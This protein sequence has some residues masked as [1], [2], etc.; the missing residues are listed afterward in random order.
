MSG[1]WNWLDDRTGVRRLIHEALY[2]RI[3][4]GARWRYVWGSTLVF[5][6][7]TQAVTGFLLWMAY[8]PGGQSAWESVYYIQHEMQYGWLLRGVH[9]FM[10]QA[11]VV[12]LVLH[13]MQVIID[14]AYRAPREINFWLGL[15]LMQLVLGL[16]LTGY[17]LPW[18][19]KGY[20]ATRVATNL[21]GL[22][23]R[24]GPDLQRLVVGG[25]DYGHH[26]LTR[27]FALHAGVLPALLVGFLALHIAVFRRQGIHAVRPEGRPLAYFWP[28]QVLRDAVACLAVMAAV[29]FLVF[30]PA[31]FGAEV[32]ERPGAVLGAELGAPADP[33]SEYSAARPEWYF[34][35]LFQ[36][37]K[38][39]PQG[40]EFL[41]AIVVPGLVML[42]LAMMPLVGRWRLGHRFN[43]GFIA[44]LLLGGVA[45]TA[46]AWR[47][48]HFAEWYAPPS[49]A[50][51]AAK[52]PYAQ[53][54]EGSRQYLAAVAQAGEAAERAQVL[55]AVDG[56]PPS[57]ALALLRADPKTMG[58]ELFA[59]HC[60]SCHSHVDGEGTGLRP[61]KISAPNLQGFA[62][63]GWIAGLLNP[64]R[65]AGPDYFGGTAHAQSE[66]GMVAFVR[67]TLAKN[68]PADIREIAAAL[69][70]EA[71]LPAQAGVDAQDLALI[72]SGRKLIREGAGCTDC[73]KFHDAGE[74]GT[75]PD[76]TGYGS[77]EWLIAMIRDAEHERF[78]AERND[79]M[80]RFA[81]GDAPAEHQVSLIEVE[82]L[83]DWLRGSWVEPRVAAVPA[84]AAETPARAP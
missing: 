49:E 13:L 80:P 36:F 57:G 32:G 82:L 16:A 58:P 3:P 28:D 50:D 75:A 6:F 26:T 65:V 66:E 7:V 12:L 72:E 20:W 5:A 60:V 2:E 55:A 22:V 44:A 56:I 43:Q 31:I 62:S 53:R 25:D 47:E 52:T 76:L 54:Y 77:R 18:D 9:H 10:A 70:A 68:D 19:Q 4:G 1:L 61:E 8:S 23:P 21:M 81:P 46:Q 38:L 69:S 24:F 83:A 63:R 37:L 59:R 51:R 33:S 78:Y 15:V 30:R 40:T 79:R 74:L 71:R 73:H 27:F 14:G 67:D 41:G 39:F 29:L 45:L 35:F 34:L 64:E 42:G 17:L 48:D 84:P 11:M